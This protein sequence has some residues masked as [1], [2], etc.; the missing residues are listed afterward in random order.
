MSPTHKQPG[1]FP[2]P[3]TQ[4]T[5]IPQEE[6][7]SRQKDTLLSCCVVE[8]G[9]STHLPHPERMRPKT[10]LPPPKSEQLQRK[11]AAKKEDCLNC[12]T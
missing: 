4:S 12:H 9:H 10:R 1:Q 7:R 3:Y 8:L 11:R 5:T 6:V 2:L